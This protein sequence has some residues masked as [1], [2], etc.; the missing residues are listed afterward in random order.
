MKSF[1]ALL[2]LAKRK[3]DF[4]QDNAWF[5]GSSTYLDAIK[6]EVDEVIEEIP[7]SRTNYLEDELADVLWNTLNALMALEQEA[8]ISAN[9]V[10]ERAC[11]KYEQR[12]TGIEAGVNWDDI[13]NEQKQA[14]AAEHQ[15]NI[16]VNPK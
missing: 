5:K 11:Q 4:D 6:K 7:K 12:M 1:D 13:K 16:L 14:L 3:S 15:V 2:E 10:L 9:N 8:G